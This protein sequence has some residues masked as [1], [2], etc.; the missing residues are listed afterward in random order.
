MI[1]EHWIYSIAIAIIAGMIHFKRTGR[2][3]SWIIIASAYAP[4]FDIAADVVFN[5]L[6]MPILF[7]G[8]PIQH[9]DFHNITVLLIYAVLVTLV[10]QLIRYKPLDTFVFASIG[11]G[12]HILQDAL[13]YNPSYPLWWPLS[14]E[15]LSIGLI[16]YSR[17]FYNIADSRVLLAG[18][19]AVILCGSIRAAYQGN[20]WIK[21]DMK[22]VTIIF[23]LWILMVPVLGAFDVSVTDK[24]TSSKNGIILE[25]WSLGN[26]AHW[27]SIIYHSGEHSGRIGV[28]GN[29]SITTG[30]LRSEMIPA[31][32][33]TTYLFSAWGKTENAN[34]TNAPVVRVIER[35]ENNKWIKQIRLVYNKGTNDW[36]QQNISFTTGVNASRFY[37]YANIW[38]DSGTFWFDDVALYEEGTYTN[39]VPDPGIENGYMIMIL[40]EFERILHS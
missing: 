15:K 33:N 22:V 30:T 5:K 29:E 8:H 25:N 34:G 13:V 28:P 6:A 31:K 21:K 36:M 32:S 3:Y 19:T 4:D 20:G 12:A 10:L 17:D 24:F 14:D 35:D 27:D 9:G 38:D 18:L 26:D 1:F 39:L 40:P 7:D 23:T 11:F 2:D 37:L 16:E